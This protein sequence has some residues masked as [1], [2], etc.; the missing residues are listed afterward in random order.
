MVTMAG[1]VPV[2]RYSTGLARGTRHRHIYNLVSGE[3]K[4]HL[5]A[6]VKRNNILHLNITVQLSVH[7]KLNELAN[8]LTTM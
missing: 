3:A 8:L 1:L 2:S 7:I 6:K 5:V 4:H